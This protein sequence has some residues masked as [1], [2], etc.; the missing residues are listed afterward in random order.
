MHKPQAT[1][2][3]FTLMEVMIVVVIVGILVMI[4]IPSYRD[5]VT[6]AW[7]SKATTCL[8]EMAQGMERR[9]TTALSYAGNPSAPGTL[10]PQVCSTE[11][12]MATY[13]AFSFAANPTATQ[14]TLRAVPQGEQATL[15]ARCGTLSINQL[16]TRTVSGAATVDDCW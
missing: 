9:Y 11:D 10:P 14:F 8:V 12:G 1:Q 15:D 5:S 4:A 6:R 16:G 2:Q 7:R 13:Y 3:G